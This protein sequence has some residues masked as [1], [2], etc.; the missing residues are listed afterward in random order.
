[1]PRS[2]A[3]ELPLLGRNARWRAPFGVARR[4]AHTGIPKA[5]L[6]GGFGHFPI[7]G[8]G[9]ATWRDES[10]TLRLDPTSFD[11]LGWNG[12]MERFLALEPR[13]Y[14]LRDRCIPDDGVE[15]LCPH[16]FHWESLNICSASRWLLA[17]LLTGWRRLAGCGDRDALSL[18]CGALVSCHR[19]LG[20]DGENR[21]FLLV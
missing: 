18:K 5:R 11:S 14:D 9:P 3:G 17:M 12:S 21:R 20:R 6:D 13:I 7:Q 8:Q 1:M 15:D 19:N 16:A 10:M 2:Q 4:P